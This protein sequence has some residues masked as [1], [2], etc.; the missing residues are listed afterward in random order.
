MQNKSSIFAKV[1]GI[2]KICWDI[3]WQSGEYKND[4][5]NWERIY[6]TRKISIWI[7]YFLRN[8]AISP[9][10]VTALWVLLGIIGGFLLLFNLYWVSIFAFFLLFLSWILDNVDGELAR[11]KK[12][13]SIAGNFLDM[14][15]HEII[16][17]VIFC[18]LT[19]S[20]VLQN[21]SHLT[22]FL[23][24][25]ATAFATPMNKM[26][27]SA[28]LL[29]CM[30]AISQGV[31]LEISKNQIH[32]ISERKNFKKVTIK[33]VAVIFS[34]VGMFYLLFIAI[35]FKVENLYLSLYGLGLPLLF[36]PK[37][38]IRSKELKKIAEDPSLLKQL[39]RPEWL[40]C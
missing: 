34:E 22:V 28:K 35:V 5:M 21:Q 33:I 24:L 10:Q 13:Y 19:F 23:G 25:L 6:F 7:T 30:K 12:Q 36:I 40:D 11:H 14:V 32:A 29:L 1:K 8:S 4:M 15:G 20:A 17:P 3:N 2:Q 26:M 38:L 9:N 39:F 16:P 31:K 27:E 37:Y 18:C